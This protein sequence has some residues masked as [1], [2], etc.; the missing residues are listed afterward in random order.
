VSGERT[1]LVHVDETARVGEDLRVAADGGWCNDL[2]IVILVDARYKAAAMHELRNDQPAF[3]KAGI[4][5]LALAVDLRRRIYARRAAIALASRA[6]LGAF[7]DDEART[8]TLAVIFNVQLGG[9]V[10]L[11][12]PATGHG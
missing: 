4:S 12:C 2:G 11:A 7:G 8:R 5:E 6:R 3:R 10:A 9:R 1:R